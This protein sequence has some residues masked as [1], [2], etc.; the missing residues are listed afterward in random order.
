MSTVK[1]FIK[2]KNVNSEQRLTLDMSVE[3]L[4]TKLELIVGIAA[5]NQILTLYRN[6]TPLGIMEDGALIGKFGIFEYDTI[7][8]N[9]INNQRLVDF[10]DLSKVEKYEIPDEEYEKLENTVLSFKKKN[11]IGRF[12]E[13][14]NARQDS[15][16]AQAIKADSPTEFASGIWIGVKLDEPLGKNDGSVNGVTYFTCM[17][18]YGSFVKPESV[19]CGDFPELMDFSDD[20]LEEL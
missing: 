3:S 13:T 8:V 9:G 6:D 4:K 2:S 10:D 5:S 20:G 14:E 19:E 16:K 17:A 1:V 11:Q 18:D 15:A 12:N 7:E